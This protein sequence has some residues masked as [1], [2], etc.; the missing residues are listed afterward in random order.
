MRK[1]ILADDGCEF[2]DVETCQF[3]EENEMPHRAIINKI[4]QMDHSGESREEIYQAIRYA[5]KI[6]IVK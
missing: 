6:Q 4:L 1:V 5:F 3:Y 2:S